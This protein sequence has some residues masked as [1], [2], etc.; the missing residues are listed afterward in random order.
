MSLSDIKLMTGKVDS[1]LNDKTILVLSSVSKMHAS[2]GKVVR[3]VKKYMI[4]C[5][6]SLEEMGVAEGKDVYFSAS[7][8]FSKRKRWLL[9]SVV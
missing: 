3:R 1:I 2:Y 9:H 7:K 8:P 4:H 6:S 5:E